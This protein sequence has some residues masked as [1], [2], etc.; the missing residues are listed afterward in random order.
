MIERENPKLPTKPS[1]PAAQFWVLQKSNSK[2]AGAKD[3]WLNVA[4]KMPQSE[5]PV[6]GKGGII[7]D[8]M[9]LGGYLPILGGRSGLADC[10]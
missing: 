5:T 7:A 9:G 1:D 8:G 6:L 2:A 10:R 3:Y 4:T